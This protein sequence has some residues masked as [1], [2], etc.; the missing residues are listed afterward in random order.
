VYAR[1]RVPAMSEVSVPLLISSLLSALASL[2]LPPSPHTASGPGLLVAQLSS[3]PSGVPLCAANSALSDY[4]SIMSA[5]RSGQPTQAGACVFSSN[6]S[7]LSFWRLRVGTLRGCTVQEV[8]DLSSS[9]GT[10]A[11]KGLHGRQNPL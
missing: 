8:C 5:P 1:R 3:V 2:L 7:L 9:L 4:V 10:Q 6:C 11:A